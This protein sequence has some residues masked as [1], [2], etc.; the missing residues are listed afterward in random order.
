MSL[1]SWYIIDNIGRG[2]SHNFEV[3]PWLSKSVPC[4][5]HSWTKK[6]SIKVQEDARDDIEHWHWDVYVVA[7]LV[8]LILC[9]SALNCAAA[10][11]DNTVTQLTN[12]QTKTEPQLRACCY[13]LKNFLECDP[14]I[15]HQNFPWQWWR[16]LSLLSC[17]WGPTSILCD[18]PLPID[19]I[20]HGRWKVWHLFIWFQICTF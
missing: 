3:G 12:M 15:L 18:D 8:Q 9:C 5:Q 7:D 2:S 17:A 13:G 14:Y 16:E 20:T 19:S 11:A 1:D 10:A 4:T 6:S